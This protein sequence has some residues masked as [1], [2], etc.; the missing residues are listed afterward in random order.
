VE[1]LVYWLSLAFCHTTKGR[2][3]RPAAA[4][5][6]WQ[7]RPGDKRAQ[8]GGRKAILPALILAG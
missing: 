1:K 7:S 3:P 5:M 2:R 4:Y 6:S 8:A